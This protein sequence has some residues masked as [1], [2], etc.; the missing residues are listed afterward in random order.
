[1]R[2]AVLE[3]GATRRA[4]NAFS[5]P[6]V[7]SA[8]ICS[9]S[10]AEQ[11]YSSALLMMPA[12]RYGADKA[13]FEKAGRNRDFAQYFGNMLK[14]LARMPR[15]S[16]TACDRMLKARASARCSFLAVEE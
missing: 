6:K 13:I 9:L 15:G 1:M 12:A 8:S 5:A 4:S 3:T 16:A 11:V 2:A 10:T 14:Q 7:G